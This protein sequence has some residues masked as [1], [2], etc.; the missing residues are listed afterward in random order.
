MSLY[1]DIYITVY[2]TDYRTGKIMLYIS[3]QQS[4]Q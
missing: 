1:S 2:S 3:L 4:E